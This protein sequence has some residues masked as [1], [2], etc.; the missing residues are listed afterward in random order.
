MSQLLNSVG[1]NLAFKFFLFFEDV[2]F[3]LARFFE[4]GGFLLRECG[5]VSEACVV[6]V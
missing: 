1:D 5:E 4:V 3:E 2:F 6:F